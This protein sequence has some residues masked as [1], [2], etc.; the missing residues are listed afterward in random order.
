MTATSPSRLLLPLCLLPLLAA[1]G[2]AD[3]AVQEV[4]LRLDAEEGESVTYRYE[5][6][7]SIT[8]P[9][10]FGS[11]TNV[12]TT[13]VVRRTAESVTPDSLRFR[14]RIEDFYLEVSARD[15]RTRAQ[16]EDVAEQARRNAVGSRFWLTMSPTGEMIRL[17]R[18][19]G[20]AVEGARVEQALRHLSFADLPPGPVTVGESWTG[21]DSLDAVSFGSPM[22]GTV[23]ADVRTTLRSVDRNGG[24][25]VAV[26]RLEGTYELHQ[27]SAS[28]ASGFSGEMQGSSD[29]TVRFDIEEGRFLSAE[30]TQD[31]TVNL[32]MPGSRS[33]DFRVRTSV[34]HSV[35]LVEGG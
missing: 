34:R 16:L 23:V 29:Q 1:A 17:R 5:T 2:P 13:M 35:R 24:R 4:R 10:Q 21:T 15:E 26:L 14:A 33:G 8:P 3:A 30:G 22:P 20:E 7:A 31:I 32:S 27:D 28:A 19:G 12:T 11:A 18:E 9:P 25:P 6:R